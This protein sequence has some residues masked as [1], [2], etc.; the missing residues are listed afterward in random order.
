MR[1]L[2]G[3]LRDGEAQ[4]DL[5][6]HAGNVAQSGDAATV[7]CPPRSVEPR[8]PLAWPSDGLKDGPAGRDHAPL[9][10]GDD[11]ADQEA[12]RWPRAAAR[13][14]AAR[15]REGRGSKAAPRRR[16]RAAAAAVSLL[17]PGALPQPRADLARLQQPRAARGGGRAHPAAGAREVPRHH[18]LEPRRVLHEAHRRPQA[19]G[20]RPACRR[21]R[22]TAARPPQ[23]ISECHAVDPRRCA[24]RMQALAARAASSCCEAEGIELVALRPARRTRS[25]PQVRAEYLRSI[26]P[27]VTPA[28]DRPGAPLPVHLQPLA[29]PAGDAALPR[30]APSSRWRAS[31]SRSGAGT[32]RFL[33]VG[34]QGALRAASRR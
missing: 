26:F 4:V 14:T 28:V 22:S 24:P 3:L 11:H 16:R 33:R 5:L 32:P 27:L 23:Q 17:D 18:R 20:R 31:R 25:R 10:R 9:G 13:K 29:E 34:A 6:E 12:A 2:V 30:R 21:P 8:P 7:Q 19:A 1:A 15:P